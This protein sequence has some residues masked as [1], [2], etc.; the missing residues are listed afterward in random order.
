MDDGSS[1]S[2]RSDYWLMRNASMLAG[3]LLPR[4]HYRCNK[5]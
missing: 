4:V 5:C 1:R 3:V 2:L